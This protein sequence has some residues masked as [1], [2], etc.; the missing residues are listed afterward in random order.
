MSLLTV[1]MY[2]YVRPLVGTVDA[3]IKGIE[4]S[5]FEAQLDHLLR[6]HEPVTLADVQGALRDGSARL[7]SNGLLLTFDD[8]YVDHFRHVFPALQVRKLHGVFFVPSGPARHGRVL[9]VNKIHF[10]L[11]RG[12]E[13][14]GLV[15]ELESRAAETMGLAGERDFATFR[16]RFWRSSRYDPAGIVYFKHM[17]QA[18]LPKA[19]RTRVV[20]DMFRLHVS[21]CEAEFA[22]SLYCNSVELQEMLRAGMALGGHGV[23]HDRLRLAD[24]ETVNAEIEGSAQFLEQLGV[25]AHAR[26]FA[27]PYG[28]YDDRA[29]A[30]VQR[31]GFQLGFAVGNQLHDVASHGAVEIQRLDTTAFPYKRSARPGDWTA[32]V[33]QTARAS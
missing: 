22:R 16:E 23:N 17:L 9:D 3:G 19:V 1:V 11:A 12:N 15:R 10:I 21:D 26:S 18:G 30:A 25:P 6:F 5:A 27:Y 2:H 4:P 32:R 24:D 7:P 29:V 20:D 8:G 33:L 13:I 28:D 14:A 31:C